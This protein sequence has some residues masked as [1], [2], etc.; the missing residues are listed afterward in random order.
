[1]RFGARIVGVDVGMMLARQL[2][3]SAFDRFLVRVALES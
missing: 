2:A 1:M 3:I